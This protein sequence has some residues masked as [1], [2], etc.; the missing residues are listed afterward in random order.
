MQQNM[1]QGSK[2]KIK[3]PSMVGPI[4]S[5]IILS[6]MHMPM[7]VLLIKGDNVPWILFF[8]ECALV[9]FLIIWPLF[10]FFRVRAFIKPS[11]L[12]ISPES[13]FINGR[14]VEANQIKIVMVMGYFKP[15]VGIKPIN[16]KYVP[17]HLCFRFLE[18]EDKGM[19]EFKSWAELN[20]I[21][22]VHKR[23]GRW[24]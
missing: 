8:I 7:V 16:K 15:I 20:Q 10:M 5:L 1:F 21:P 6:I 14:T 23:F 2:F 17:T 3:Y 22:F 13:L 11:I 19:K 18:D 9:L 24:I 4:I 12:H